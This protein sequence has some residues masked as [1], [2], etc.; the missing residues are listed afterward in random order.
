MEKT[1]VENTLRKEDALEDS[2]A[3]FSRAEYAVLSEACRKQLC[4]FERELN[5]QGCWN[6]ALVAYQ[7]KD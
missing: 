6:V 7:L 2:R 1:S 5:R 4:E 3:D